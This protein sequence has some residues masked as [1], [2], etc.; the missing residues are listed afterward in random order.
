MTY[1]DELHVYIKELELMVH[2]LQEQVDELEYELNQT[3]RLIAILDSQQQHT[4]L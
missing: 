4:D 1:E 3:H 2:D